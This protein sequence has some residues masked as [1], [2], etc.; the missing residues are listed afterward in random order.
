M[1]KLILVLSI[2]LISI[3]AIPTKAFEL[4]L[5]QETTINI[6]ADT[7]EF[8]Y[9]INSTDIIYDENKL[10]RT[11]H[12][13]FIVIDPTTTRI[14]VNP[15]A[16]YYII[17]LNFVTP[18]AS[19]L[20]LKKFDNKYYVY[21]NEQIL[22]GDFNF[23]VDGQDIKG[24]YAI[25]EKITLNYQDTTISNIQ[26]KKYNEITEIV[27]FIL[28]VSLIFVILGYLIYL[29]MPK[30]YY[31]RMNKTA[32]KIINLNTKNKVAQNILKI[33]FKLTDLNIQFRA[34]SSTDPIHTKLKKIIN[35][36]NLVMENIIK[37]NG[38]TNDISNDSLLLFYKNKAQQLINILDN[39]NYKF[40]DLKAN[41]K[42]N[43][44]IFVNKLP[45]KEEQDAIHY[46]E[47]V[48]IINNK[49]EKK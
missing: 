36:M 27:I 40:K 23:I 42:P 49:V 33:R 2:F 1:K 18:N 4:D 19:D 30:N 3:I 24:L 12:D 35:E 45:N 9:V 15:D 7:K 28:G 44:K 31:K 37:V 26:P 39:G 41:N 22:Y 48:N 34:I 21:Y 6:L 47:G 29:F 32:K 43:K 38:I 8:S 46:L 5:N 11:E 10:Y 17:N 16:N 25:G 14:I 20:S 13:T